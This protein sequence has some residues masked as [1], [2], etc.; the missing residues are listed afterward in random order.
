MNERDLE[1]MA[2][3]ASEVL[4]RAFI[5]NGTKDQYLL[6]DEIFDSLLNTLRRL[7]LDSDDPLKDRMLNLYV[8]CIKESD[9]VAS[10]NFYGSPEW[11]NVRTAMRNF[12]LHLAKFDLEAW[13]KRELAD[14]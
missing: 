13:E 14:A 3:M 12:L 9:K 4:H 7:V 8:Y 6:P 5:D 11:I 1:S 10:G 2:R